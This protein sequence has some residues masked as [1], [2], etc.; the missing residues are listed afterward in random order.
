MFI[1]H[2]NEYEM[3]MKWNENKSGTSDHHDDSNDVE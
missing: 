1:S 2:M 3:N